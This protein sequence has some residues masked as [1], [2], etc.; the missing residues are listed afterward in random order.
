VG[1][2][3]VV[4]VAGALIAGFSKGGVFAIATPSPVPPGVIAQGVVTQF[5]DDIN[6]Q[7]MNDAYGLLATTTKKQLPYQEWL[8]SYAA[9]TA[10][11]A[12]NFQSTGRDVSFHLVQNEKTSVGS[13]TTV[14]EGVWKMVGDD[15]AMR[16]GEHHLSILYSTYFPPDKLSHSATEGTYEKL[17]QSLAFVATRTDDGVEAGSAFCVGS[18]EAYS[19][20]LTNSHVVPD[21]NERL[22]VPVI[23]GTPVPGTVLFRD[24]NRD[25]AILQ[26]GVP[27][28]PSVVLAAG[29]PNEGTSVAIAGYPDVQIQIAAADLGLT[30]S[31]HI[32][33]VNALVA[34]GSIIEY[35]ATTDHGN[36]GGPLFDPSTGIVY[37]VVTWGL[38]SSQ[39]SAVQN[40]FAISMRDILPFVKSTKLRILT[41]GLK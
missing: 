27:A 32:G 5:Y 31:M 9:T 26:V 7:K 25:L 6:S 37:G 13:L 41:T 1:G 29:T 8:K 10:V 15:G 40:N 12:S 3:I 20:F 22:I 36:S 17:K 24:S 30:P 11:S 14:S 33:V 38:Q 19:Y 2:L 16:L 35:D 4:V 28:I 39:S 21:S 23:S 34:D 18:D